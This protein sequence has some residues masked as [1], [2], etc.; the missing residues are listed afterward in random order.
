M[1]K[2]SKHVFTS[3]L[4]R[5]ANLGCKDHDSFS[6]LCLNQ[7]KCVFCTFNAQQFFACLVPTL[8]VSSKKLCWL[9]ILILSL[10]S[11]WLCLLYDV[12][13]LC[14][15]CLYP[16][17][18]WHA[19]WCHF[20]PKVY[21]QNFLPFEQVQTLQQDDVIYILVS[22][23]SI[24]VDDFDSQYWFRMMSP[25]STMPRQ[26]LLMLLGWK[27]LNWAEDWLHESGTPMNNL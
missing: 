13:L 17:Q 11:V 24:S 18:D 7:I 12:C 2:K 21:K 15:E 16:L 10:F 5:S 27:F 22:I 23:F 14:V 1:R 6:A 19:G 26:I 20:S 4:F 9:I 25:A 8:Q 3:N